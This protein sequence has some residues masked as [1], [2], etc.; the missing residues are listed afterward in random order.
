MTKEVGKD[1]KQDSKTHKK[2]KELGRED[3]KRH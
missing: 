1:K 3:G 2:R